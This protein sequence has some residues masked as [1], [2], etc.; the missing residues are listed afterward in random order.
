M[1]DS[2]QNQGAFSLR[3]LPK[4]IKGSFFD[5]LKDI[6]RF[7]ASVVAIVSAGTD[8][9]SAFF[10]GNYKCLPRNNRTDLLRG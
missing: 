1:A 9:V 7:L 3:K 4:V 8:F 10:Y 5:L 6:Q 2:K